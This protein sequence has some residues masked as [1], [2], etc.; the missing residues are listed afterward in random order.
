MI[1]VTPLLAEKPQ[2]HS[3][4]LPP[5]TA[6][7]RTLPNGLTVI[8]DQDNS[9]PVASV[10]VW[11]DSGSIHEGD[12]LGAGMSHILEHMLFKGTEK[13]GGGDIAREAQEVGGRMNAYT[14]FDRTVYYI[15]L[16]ADGVSVAIDILTDAMLNSTL[17]E[18]EYVK[19]Q[20]V[21][22]REFAMGFDDPGR[23][24]TQLM[25]RTA[26]QKSPYRH[27]VIG[28]LDVY[29]ML[30][31]EDVMNYYR[32]RYV[33]N[34]MT[35]VISGD[36]DPDAVFSQIEELF[37]DV[38]RKAL[39]PIYLPD[40]PKQIS[41]R[42]AHEEFPTDLTRLTLAW[43]IPGI[44]HPDMPA[45]S[46]LGDVLGGGR[47]APLYRE[48]RENRNLAHEIDAGSYTPEK[49]GI[50]GVWAVTDPDKREELE[51]AILEQLDL[52]KE[53]GPDPTDLERARKANLSTSLRG[54]QTASGRARDLGSNWQLTRNLDFSREFLQKVAELT[55][56]DLQRV[57]NKY[58]TPDGLTVTS[59]NPEGTVA[60]QDSKIERSAQ[61]DVK[62]FELS[63]GM[64]L[65]VLADSRLPLVSMVVA[66]RGG[67]IAENKQNNGISSLMAKTMIKGTKTRSSDE[68]ASSIEQVGGVLN[69]DAG[70]NTFNVSVDILKS[71][72]DLGLDLLADVV[73]NPTFPQNEVEREK[74]AQIA[75]IKAREDQITAIGIDALRHELFGDHNYGLKPTGTI[76]T[77]NNLTRE[78]I[79]AFREKLVSADN[80]VLAIFGDVNPDE[81]HKMAEARFG[82]LPQGEIIG[83]SGTN[84]PE[85][86]G[87]KIVET[88]ED[89]QQA[90]IMVGY[91]AVEVTSPDLPKLEILDAISSDLSSRF[92]MRI[93]DEKSLAYFVGSTIQTGID[94]GAFVF[95]LGTDPDRLDEATTELRAEIE[96]MVRNGVTEDELKRAKAKIAGTEARRRQNQGAFAMSVAVDE[97]VGLGYDH[98]KHSLDAIKAV[99]V[100]DAN[101]AAK[102]YFGEQ[103]SVESIVRPPQKDAGEASES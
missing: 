2:A 84:P 98:Y 20:E 38:P 17:P 81:V 43:K 93:R 49:E 76:E 63:N 25:F 30:T 70:N 86:E 87:R 10:Q 19:E 69:A 44:T 45:L 68:I 35:F 14:T 11:V 33:P 15:D 39:E 12:W 51:A 42:E 48:L 64:R 50:F 77:I 26:F 94:P 36:V 55:P 7:V 71:D 22:R 91:P 21:I 97:L 32:E 31:R 13:R 80:G 1:A 88:L 37:A 59:L 65:L 83:K 61:P 62:A 47:S 82:T 66:F 67:L 78:A 27:P 102:K 54:L 28:H 92:F 23:M 85:I 29:N 40:E 9:A 100:E 72:L 41:K 3:I 56:D 103:G 89:K 60:K 57:A 99:T 90:V 58:L 52:V 6:E 24:S 16:P 18:D 101:R 8:V 75:E 96:E 53:N 34:N 73:Q 79:E 4:E 74:Q 46:V 95:Y 5:A